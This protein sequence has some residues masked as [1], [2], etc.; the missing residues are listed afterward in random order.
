MT[1]YTRN[2]Y[3]IAIFHNIGDIL[4]C[5]PIAKQLKAD[6]PTCHITWF[7][8]KR[9]AFVLDN[10]PYIDE[11]IALPDVPLDRRRIIE[12]LKQYTTAENAGIYAL[13][14]EIPRLRNSRQWTR[15]FTPAPYLNYGELDKFGPDGSLLDII[16][17][18]ANLKWTVPDLPVVRLTDEE[19][20][21]ARQ[22]INRLPSG[23]K[24]LIET[25]YKSYQSYFDLDCLTGIITSTLNLKPVMIFSSKNKPDFFDDVAMQYERMYWF[26][27]DFRLNA[28]LYN[29]CN[30]FIGVSS[31]ISTL[32]YSD[33]C[34]R[35]L[36]KLEAC[37]GKHWSAYQRVSH[38]NLI[39]CYSKEAFMEKLDVFTSML[40]ATQLN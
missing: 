15:F 12:N 8:S 29:A 39:P 5:T 11:V 31:G 38:C 17:S 4:L 3:G 21:T 40:P 22:Y 14:A 2:Q 28:E 34:R 30:G 25:E 24:I 13:N 26:A 16:K 32:T 10:N 18:Y 9:Y 20:K 35:D 19:I 1:T 27:G 6:D 33:W 23:I 37:L 36:P 7:T